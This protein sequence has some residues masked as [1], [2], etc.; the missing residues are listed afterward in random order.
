M[1]VGDR[2][3]HP[4]SRAIGLRKSA[5]VAERT[6]G[7]DGDAVLFAPWDHGMLDRALAQV[8]EHLIAGGFARPRDL[9]QLVEIVHVEIADAP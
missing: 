6:I 2:L 8:I 4:P 7:D 9:A 5:D 1:P 3:Q